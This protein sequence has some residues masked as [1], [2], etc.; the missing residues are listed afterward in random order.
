MRPSLVLAGNPSNC[1]LPRFRSSLTCEVAVGTDQFSCR[2]Y[3]SGEANG[4][5]R[6]TCDEGDRHRIHLELTTQGPAL[7]TMV[8]RRRRREVDKVV[9]AINP[10]ERPITVA[11]WRRFAAVA[12]EV[13]QQPW[14]T[15]CTPR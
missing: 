6:A 4:Q 11:A 3:P 7:D 8:S 5:P 13:P 2:P 1:H 9:N 12:A 15:G 10:E 14:S